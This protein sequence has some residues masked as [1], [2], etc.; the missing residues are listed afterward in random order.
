M[1]R[2]VRLPQLVAA[3]RRVLETVGRLQQDVGGALDQ[4]GG[5][6]DP[7]D[8]RL[9]EKLALSV[10]DPASQLARREL[11]VHQ[12]RLDPLRPNPLR[13]PV[14]RMDYLSPIEFERAQAA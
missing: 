12:G 3:T 1:I 5:L 11:G 9:R 4:V 7:G 14:S 13:D 10:R 8:A 2:E 6:Q